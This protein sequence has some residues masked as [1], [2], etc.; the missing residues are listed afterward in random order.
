METASINDGHLDYMV[1]NPWEKTYQTN[2]GSVTETILLSLLTD[3]FKT[4]SSY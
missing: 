4:I 2:E 3:L 1:V